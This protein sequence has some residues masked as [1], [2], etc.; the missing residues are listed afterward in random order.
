MDREAW[1][2]AIHE[3]AKSRTRL[4]DWTELNWTELNQLGFPGGS[5][6]E[7]TC[8][9]RRCRFDS[10]VG[11][12]LWRRKR[13]PT[14]V[15]LPGKSHAQRSLVGYSPWG[16]KDSDTTEWLNNNKCFRIIV[17]LC[18]FKM[19]AYTPD[20]IFFIFSSSE[21][22]SMKKYKLYGG[23]KRHVKLP[24]TWKV[25]SAYNANQECLCS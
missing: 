15:F 25:Y 23:N 16:H 22:I 21:I 13:Q 6:V 5:V 2:A 4:S 20:I 8:Q 12:I 1:R 19:L 14:P 11:K 18:I 10:C 7:S 3:V 9:C 24:L 17:L